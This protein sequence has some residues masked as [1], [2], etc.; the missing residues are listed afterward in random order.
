[1]I[2]VDWNPPSDKPLLKDALSIPNDLG[3]LVI[4]FIVVPRQI[5]ESYKCSPDMKIAYVAALNVGIRRARGEFIWP[6]NSDLL[7]SNEMI[8]FLSSEKLEK[9]RFYRAFR[10]C[11]PE[12]V[13]KLKSASLKER[14]DFCHNNVVFVHPRNTVSIH[15]LPN[16]PIL[17]T[18]TG[19]DFIVFSKEYWQLLHGYV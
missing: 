9:D 5:H 17:Q 12:D 11:V 15:G 1:M 2:I 13:L 16:H 6:T 7:F 8:E 14:L 19:G 18:S 3:P 10:Y 4:R